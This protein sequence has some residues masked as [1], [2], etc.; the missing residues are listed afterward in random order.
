MGLL[1]HSML[2]DKPEYSINKIKK[3]VID[4]VFG[5]KKKN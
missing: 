1:F 4:H 2:L 5:A 3:S